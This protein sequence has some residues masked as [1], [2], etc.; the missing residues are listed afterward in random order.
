MNILVN[1]NLDLLTNGDEGTYNG[2]N[3][4]TQL[5]SFGIDPIRLFTG[6]YEDINTPWYSDVGANF[7]LTV[8]LNT[9][10]PIVQPLLNM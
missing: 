4:A 1:A 9:F 5:A 2:I 3:A 6:N 7:I 8:T 10:I